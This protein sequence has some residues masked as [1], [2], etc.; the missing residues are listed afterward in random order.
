[1]LFALGIVPAVAAELVILYLL[2]KPR[3]KADAPSGAL[4]CI[5]RCIELLPRA[6]TRR[7][8][9]RLH[10]L[11]GRAK[12]RIDR[13][14]IEDVYDLDAVDALLTDIKRLCGAL[15]TVCPQDPLPYTPYLLDLLTDCEKKLAALVGDSDATR[16]TKPARISARKARAEDL[17]ADVR[18]QAKNEN[19]AAQNDRD[20]SGE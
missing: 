9:R 3:P 7:E 17:L 4:Y 13:A 11:A 14:K 20:I 15:H 1:M 10:M 8:Y 18:A 16:A 19:N 5:R 12:E 6:N 2:V